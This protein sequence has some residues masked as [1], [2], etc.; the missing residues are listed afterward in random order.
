MN[1][2]RYKSPL[3]LMNCSWSGLV[4]NFASRTSFFFF[5]K[6][7]EIENNVKNLH[8]CISHEKKKVVL[9]SDGW[10]SSLSFCQIQPCSQSNTQYLSVFNNKKKKKK[11]MKKEKRRK[12]YT[13][14]FLNSTWVPKSTLLELFKALRSPNLEWLL[15][16][17]LCQLKQ[18]K[19]RALV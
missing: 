19:Y 12:K 18:Y 17:A 2:E 16:V 7:W 8:Q 13:Y 15:Y 5:C 6:V 11:K 3:S 1:A 9:L 14:E 4:L 10:S